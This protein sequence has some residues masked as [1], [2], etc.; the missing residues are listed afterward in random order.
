MI[1]AIDEKGWIY[2]GKKDGYGMLF[3]ANKNEITDCYW[4]DD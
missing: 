1:D 2:G 3:N 4:I